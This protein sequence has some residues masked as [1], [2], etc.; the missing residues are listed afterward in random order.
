MR[1][2][3]SIP[4]ALALLG[5]LVSVT[6]ALADTRVG[7]ELR[8]DHEWT[9]AGS[10]YIL[11]SDLTITKEGTLRIGPGVTVRA[12]ANIADFT[13]FNK[14]DIDI[15][16]NGVLEAHG[17]EGDS[18]YFTSD[19][20]RPRWQDWQ[21]IVI[22][23]GGR[24]D[25]S[26]THLEFANTAI[27]V[28]EGDLHLEGSTIQFCE[29]YGVHFLKTGGVLDDVTITQIGNTGGSGI[30]VWIDVG[31]DPV[32]KN[33]FIVGAQNGITCSRLAKGTV[34]YTVISLC[35]GNGLTIRNSNPVIHNT[36]VSGNEYGVVLSWD[37]MPTLNNNNFFNNGTADVFIRDY[38]KDVVKIDLSNNFWG[39]TDLAVIE[40][41]V[42]DGV[43]NENVK[44]F[45]IVEPFLESAVSTDAGADAGR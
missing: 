2:S 42:L 39:T 37:S 1:V 44:A 23:K 45:A 27:L 15:I 16:V 22:Q 20:D 30:G 40:D 13:G 36:T 11:T 17:A 21:G 33:S 41:A 28:D 14:F 19:A 6:G 34:S 8:G 29:L 12:K 18:I 3:R 31:A 26:A 25:I 35:T 7:G 4:T 5:V 10:P 9:K 24:A 32:I 43:D 38:K